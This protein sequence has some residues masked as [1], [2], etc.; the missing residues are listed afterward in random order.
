M[1]QNILLKGGLSHRRGVLLGLAP[2]KGRV[3]PPPQTETLAMALTYLRVRNM[4]ITSSITNK[5]AMSGAV[6][7]NAMV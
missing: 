5:I 2:L 1:Q 6:G 7:E 3:P 4:N